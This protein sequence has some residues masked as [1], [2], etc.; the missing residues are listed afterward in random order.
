MQRVDVVGTGY[1]GR[2]LVRVFHELEALSVI[3][4]QSEATLEL[5]RR[6]Y[7]EAD[8]SLALTDVLTR[9]DVDA[10]VIASPAATHS[11]AAREALHACKHVF[12]EK[13]LTLRNEE[14][15][16][17]IEL[18]AQYQRVLMGGHLLQ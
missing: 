8:S 9:P 6:D 7:P 1:W 17:L 10:V 2:N 16:E 3:C 11:Q 15:E 12:V 14:A 5:M 18:A 13:P 4:D